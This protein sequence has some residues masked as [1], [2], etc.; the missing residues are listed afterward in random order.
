MRVHC[1]R[2]PV[3]ARSRWSASR[4]VVGRAEVIQNPASVEV[5]KGQASESALALNVTRQMYPLLDREPRLL[6]SA[7]PLLT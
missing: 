1:E 5:D 7:D 3:F 4:R 2:N 6:T